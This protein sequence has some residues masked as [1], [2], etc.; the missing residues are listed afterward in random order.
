M[1]FEPHKPPQGRF[2]RDTP[3]RPQL[4]V[5]SH[6]HVEPLVEYLKEGMFFLEAC[7]L[8]GIGATT[9]RKWIKAGIAD[10]KAGRESDAALFAQRVNAAM[11]EAKLLRVRAL[12]QAASNPAFWAAAAWWLERRYPQ[13]FGRQDRMNMNITGNINRQT[14]IEVTEEEVD[15]IRSVLGKLGESENDDSQENAFGFDP[16]H[17]EW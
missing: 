3:G 11:A 6:E 12:N 2:K 9:A 15:A 14:E 10:L 4:D 13:Q 1:S 16:S 17:S 5:M 8:C 7:H